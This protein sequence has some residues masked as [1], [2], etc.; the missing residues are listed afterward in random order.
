MRALKLVSGSLILVALALTAAQAGTVMVVET[1]AYDPYS[2]SNVATLYLGDGKIRAD[3][4]QK[5]KKQSVI[6]D[7]TNKDA[8]VM[9]ILDPA[10]LTYT[11]MDKGAMDKIR[12]AVQSQMEMFNTY[13]AKMTQEEKAEF[14]Q[15]YKKNLRRGEDMVKF[16][17]RM[18][19]SVYELAA[20]GEKVKNWTCERV[21][22]MLNKQMY[23]EVWVAPFAELGV[24]PADLAVITTVTEAFKSFAGD[25]QPFVARKVQKSDKPID[26]FPV[27]TV[28][29]EEGNKIVREEVK[30]I[31]K[32]DVDPKLFELP[33][34]YKETPLE[35][36]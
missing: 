5:E 27:K 6:F 8:P 18:K 7:A 3:V 19:K 22:V 16:D 23:K 35:G 30:E 21:N 1:W 12:G 2:D 9:W 11:K 20:S 29:Y 13:T 25:T 31:R 15:Q 4:V 24:D 34:D 26:G 28:Y 14:S 36:Q 32:E 17:D 10:A 33:A